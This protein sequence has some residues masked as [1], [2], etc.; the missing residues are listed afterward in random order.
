[1]NGRT[2]QVD[3]GITPGERAD[4]PESELVERRLVEQRD[5]AGERAEQRGQCGA[6]EREADG[7]GAAAA[8]R[9]QRVHQHRRDR[10]ADEGE[11]HESRS[12]R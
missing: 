1:M 4:R 7:V 11:P 8:H 10:R 2:C 9:S 12:P 3:V 5:R 6:G